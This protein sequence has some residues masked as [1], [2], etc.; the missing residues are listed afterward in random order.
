MRAAT[1][2]SWPGH[3]GRDEDRRVGVAVGEPDRGRA[4]AGRQTPRRRAR[5]DRR[6]R[7]RPCSG[8]THGGEVPAGLADPRTCDRITAALADLEAGRAR[9]LESAGRAGCRPTCRG[10]R[11]R[12]APTRALAPLPRTSPAQLLDQATAAQQAKIDDWQRNEQAITATAEQAGRCSRRPTSWSGAPPPGWTSASPPPTRSVASRCPRVF[13]PGPQRHRPAAADVHQPRV[14]VGDP[15][16]GPAPGRRP[17]PRL[18]GRRWRRR[19]SGL[20]QPG[21]G[22]IRTGCM[23]NRRR[24]R[25]PRP[26]A[27]IACSFR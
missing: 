23:G 16:L 6:G 20:V 11:G 25:R 3:P 13:G 18:S 10:R 9:P 27:V 14:R 19:G 12:A 15:G 1:W 24:P 26:V 5:R 2:G 4:A 17:C 7:G 8:P 22:R 21:G